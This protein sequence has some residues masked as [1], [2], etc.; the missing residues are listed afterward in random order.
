MITDLYARMDECSRDNIYI[1]L[2][3]MEPIHLKKVQQ[4]AMLMI[5]SEKI[6][7]VKL[8]THFVLSFEPSW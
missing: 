4:N 1:Y 3:R 6:N 2:I 7:Y 5:R 8:F